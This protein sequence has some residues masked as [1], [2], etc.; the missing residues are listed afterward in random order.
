MDTFVI[1]YSMLYV[2]YM[3]CSNWCLCMFEAHRFTDF[4]KHFHIV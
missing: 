2:V 1:V 4:I 3:L